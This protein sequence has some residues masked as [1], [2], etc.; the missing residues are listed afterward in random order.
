M[1]AID[2][3][4]DDDD[5]ISKIED[6]WARLKM[7]LP[8]EVQGVRFLSG[9]II[10]AKPEDAEKLIRSGKAIRVDEN[11]NIIP[12]SGDVQLTSI[13]TGVTVITYLG[14]GLSGPTT[15]GFYT[16]ALTVDG[17]KCYFEE[18]ELKTDMSCMSRIAFSHKCNMKNIFY[19]KGYVQSFF[20]EGFPDSPTI[21]REETAKLNGRGE[22]QIKAGSTIKQY[23]NI[24]APCLIDPLLYP[25]SLIRHHSNVIYYPDQSGISYPNIKEFD[26]T[27]TPQNDNCYH[28]G[29]IRF[30]VDSF[31]N[32]G[33][34]PADVEVI[35]ELTVSL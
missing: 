21:E 18:Q 25:L 20:F 32:E 9:A 33:C 13:S 26:I 24:F 22:V 28:N 14:G 6:G 15:S 1:D 8:G 27:F 29:N 17:Q 2:D 12:A 34:C 5:D 23:C 19:D 31:Q 30:L 7:I 4:D 10:D 3:D 35:A 11:G 16:L